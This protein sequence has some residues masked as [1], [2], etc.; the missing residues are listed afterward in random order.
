MSSHHFVREG[1]EPA[2]IVADGADCL[3][4]LLGQLL[5]WAPFVL[6][7]DGAL[8]RLHAMGIKADAVLGDGESGVFADE[9][10]LAAQAPIQRIHAPSQDLTDLD[11]GIEWLLAKGHKAINIVWATGW[12]ADH[13]ITNLTNLVRWR[14]QATLRLLD[15][16][17]IVYPLPNDFTKDYAAGTTIS[18]VPVGKVEGIVTKNL[19]FALNDEPLELGHRAGT[20]N[21]VVADGIVRISYKSGDLLMMECWD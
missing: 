3:P 13:T 18:L 10:L 17:S 12:R 8:A 16:H 2:L 14:H 5:E 9:D 11:K 4:E 21:R 15:D 7:L 1:Q 20:S 6:A 19:L